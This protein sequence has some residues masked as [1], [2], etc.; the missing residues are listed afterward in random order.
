MSENRVE[1]WKRKLLD[2]SMRN[3]LLNAKDGRKFL[4]IQKGGIYSSVKVGN[5]VIPYSSSEAGERIGVG[6]ELGEKEIRKRLKELYTTSRSNYNETGINSLFLAVGFLNWNEKDGEEFHHAPLILIPA[7]LVRQNA[8]PGYKLQRT[9]EDAVVNFCL[10]EMLR[11]QYALS[12]NDIDGGNI[13]DGDPDFNEVFKSF[14]KAIE[15]K[16]EW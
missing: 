2:L 5:D 8:A 11:S 13:G 9:D 10:I 14:A 4:P 1:Q 3:P 6:S 16:R 12:I 15:N 7:E